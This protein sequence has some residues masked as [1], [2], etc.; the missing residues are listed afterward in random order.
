MQWFTSPG[1]FPPRG[2]GG[3]FSRGI[4]DSTPLGSSCGFFISR[5]LS[6]FY[7]NLQVKGPWLLSFP[8][9]MRG[10]WIAVIAWEA[11]LVSLPA[12]S[13]RSF[14]RAVCTAD[15]LIDNYSKYAQHLNSIGS[16]TSGKFGFI[17]HS[18]VVFSF[19]QPRI[20]T[21]RNGSN[22]KVLQMM[23]PWAL[24]RRLPPTRS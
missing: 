18:V 22:G 14:A 19:P 8:L 4:C 10:Y 20:T 24:S 11:L 23:G 6:V 13:G 1:A 2:S 21:Q 15:L 3:C 5:L 17:S 9:K 16:W 7:P 12:V